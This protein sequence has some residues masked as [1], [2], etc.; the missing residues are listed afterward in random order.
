ME[1]TAFT[2]SEFKAGKEDRFYG[3]SFAVRCSGEGKIRL[4]YCALSA[5][6]RGGNARMT[7]N[8]KN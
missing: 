2:T 5:A 8:E 4:K 6:A 3:V 7:S 1:S